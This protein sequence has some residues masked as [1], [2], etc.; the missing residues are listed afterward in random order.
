MAEP[1]YRVCGDAL[2]RRV[3]DSWIVSNPRTHTHVEIDAITVAAI[4][5]RGPNAPQLEWE[6]SLTSGRGWDRTG[7]DLDKGLISDPT[8]CVA[9]RGD[10]VSAAQL[11]ELLRRRWIVHRSDGS[12]YAAFLAPM[13]SVLDRSH[14]GTFHQRVGQWQAV[15]KRTREKWKWW[16][17]TKFMQ[18]GRELRSGPYK[19]IQLSFF[20]SYFAAQRLTGTTILD[21]A[22]GNGFYSRKFAKAGAR[23]IGVDTAPELIE[24][25]RANSSDRCIFYQPE[26]ASACLEFLRSLTTGSIDRVYLSDIFL[27][28]MDNTAPTDLVGCLVAE[29][30]RLLQSAGHLHMFEPNSVFWLS[31]RF[32]PP[33]SPYVVATEYRQ[34]V[35]NVAP[36]LDQIVTVM[37][38]GGFLLSELIHPRMASQYAAADPDLYAFTERFPLWDFLTFERR[39]P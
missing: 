20:D 36:T 1:P 11:F 18:D 13:T 30:C 15:E 9:R 32:G 28:L 38:A 14:L 10:G 8:G 29:F 37:S 19:F 3:E 35:Y 23:V 2:L 39:R 5:A 17:D 21:F 12:D 16:H 34:R 25:A 4:A 26:S 31:N 24:I 7:L 33:E 27:L 22:C 6:D